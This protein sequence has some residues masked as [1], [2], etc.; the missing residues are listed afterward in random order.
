MQDIA[1]QLREEADV[2]EV[3]L[4]SGAGMAARLLYIMISHA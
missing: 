1:D 4:I 3:F 2:E